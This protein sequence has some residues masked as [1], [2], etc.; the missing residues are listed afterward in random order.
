MLGHGIEV[1]VIDRLPAEL[2]A[3]L[4]DQRHAQSRLDHRQRQLVG[5]A[6]GGDL[7]ARQDPAIP[8]VDPLI[9]QIAEVELDASG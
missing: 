3:E 9:V 1:D 8:F 7:V 6:A 2:G 5:P 4:R